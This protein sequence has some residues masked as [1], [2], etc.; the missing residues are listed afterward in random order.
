MA[1][2]VVLSIRR[3]QTLEALIAWSCVETQTLNRR[4]QCPER[5]TRVEGL[6]EQYLVQSTVAVGCV[7]QIESSFK[8]TY[9]IASL[10]KKEKN[11]Y[12]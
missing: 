7:N 9:P 5:L 1:N 11:Q 10:N 8:H 12:S 3:C 4:C 2:R 6:Y